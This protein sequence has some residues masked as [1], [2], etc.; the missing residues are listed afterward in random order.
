M[1]LPTE[2]II[3]DARR[4]CMSCGTA[5]NIK[6]LSNDAGSYIGFVCPQCGPYSRES[7][8]Y[9]SREDAQ[10]ALNLGHWNY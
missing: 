5:L 8:Y 1:A 7:R 4:E 9:P 10:T 2:D 3:N 6:V